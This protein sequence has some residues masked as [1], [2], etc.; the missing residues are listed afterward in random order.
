[1]NHSH[2][3][4]RHLI[5]QLEKTR[6]GRAEHPR[7]NRP[8]P[9]WM[10]RFIAQAAELF[11]PFSGLARVGYE[12]IRCGESWEISLFLSEQEQVGGSADGQ[13]TAVNFRFNVL[14]LSQCFSRLES[15]TWNAFPNSHVCF[16][17]KGDLAFLIARGDVEG[18]QV[19]L[20]ILAAPPE[21]IGPGMRAY[22]D[23]RIELV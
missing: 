10:G 11:E 15:L 19:S 5:R 9:L 22:A 13:I 8:L 17:D 12:T 23:G 18:T 1:M 4:I 7:G 6:E 14:G 3:P 20:Q 21:H 16:D 2:V